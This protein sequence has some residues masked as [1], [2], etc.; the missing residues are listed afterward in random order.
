VQDSFPP[1]IFHREGQMSAGMFRQ[2]LRRRP[3]RTDQEALWSWNQQNPKSR[4]NNL[5]FR[6]AARPTHGAGP[7]KAEAGAGAPTSAR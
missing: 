1:R 2:P 7:T 6:C 5:G 4:L 3:A